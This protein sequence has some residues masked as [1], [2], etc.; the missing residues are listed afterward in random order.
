MKLSCMKNTLLFLH[1]IF[2]LLLVLTI[3]L[4]FLL[5][6]INPT[7]FLLTI[8]DLNSVIQLSETLQNTRDAKS[9]ASYIAIN[10]PSSEF[11]FTALTIY[12]V[13]IFNQV[14]ALVSILRR[15]LCVLVFSL[16]TNL[17]IFCLSV[18][19]LKTNLFLVL[20]SLILLSIAYIHAL[21]QVKSMVH[22][23]ATVSNS[24]R[25]SPDNF[26]PSTIDGNV[27]MYQASHTPST[28]N[29]PKI[30]AP[31]IYCPHTFQE[32]VC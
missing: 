9:S 26:H 8:F 4:S 2:L 6:G 22:Q 18:T 19:F 12:L 27:Q 14:I 21:R 17:A 11:L 7:L 28:P 16:V 5:H 31:I 23:Y 20:L 13:C 29:D 10:S 32:S 24:H 15:H 3:L 25:R 30:L 1:L